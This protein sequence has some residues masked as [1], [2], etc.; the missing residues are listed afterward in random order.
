MNEVSDAYFAAESMRRSVLELK[1]EILKAISEG[2]N[3]QSHIIQRSNISWSM[4]Q[5]F[6]RRLERQGLIESQKLKGRK[7]FIITE[8]GSRVLDSYTMMLREV[9]L[10]IPLINVTAK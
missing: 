1:I 6:I 8:R 10:N 5:G 3:K 7:L 2:V 9:E 4:A